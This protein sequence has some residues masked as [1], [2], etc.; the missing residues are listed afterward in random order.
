MSSRARIAVARRRGFTLLEILLVLMLMIAVWAIVWPALDKPMAAERLRASADQ[1]RSE[2]TRGRVA[3]MRTGRAHV[4]S[5]DLTTGRFTL[6]PA[7]GITPTSTT[8]PVAATSPTM[9]VVAPPGRTLPDGIRLTELLAVD[10]VTPPP[11]VAQ[12]QP[13]TE[14][15]VATGPAASGSP[16]TTAMTSP[17]SSIFFHPDGSTSS[18]RITLANQHGV[19]LLLEL[20]GLTGATRVVELPNIDP[21]LGGTTSSGATP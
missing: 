15:Q 5:V 2:L 10:D 16:T 21:T 7:D 1:L 11:A 14:T 3:A 19:S 6:A 9:S 13:P 18:A 20:R 12:Q 17:P 8:A 4:L